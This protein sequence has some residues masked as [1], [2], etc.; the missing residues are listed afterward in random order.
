MHRTHTFP[1]DF[2]LFLPSGR[3][4]DFEKPLQVQGELG[5][6]DEAFAREVENGWN[7]IYWP[8]CVAGEPKNRLGRWGARE[9]GRWFL[10]QMEVILKQAAFAK[11]KG[12]F[13]AGLAG[14]VLWNLIS[15][16]KGKQPL[17]TEVSSVDFFVSHSWSCP[18]W[19]KVLAICYH[20][21]LDLA[22]ALSSLACFLGLLALRIYAGSL[23]RVASV[24]EGWLY[25]TLMCSPMA[26]FLLTFFLGF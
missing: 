3:I 12:L 9:L 19:M 1:D 13:K 21:N 17:L 23:S 22:I 8:L 16:T 15:P 2:A 20:L 5:F 24:G 14:D 26:V 11:Q 4:L 7:L 10:L 18:S 6:D 25:G